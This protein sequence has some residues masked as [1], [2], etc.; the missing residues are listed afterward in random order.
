MTV[1]HGADS[2]R[3]WFAP[4]AIGAGEGAQKQDK[5]NSLKAKPHSC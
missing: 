3:D 5:V 1:N 4:M 2:Y